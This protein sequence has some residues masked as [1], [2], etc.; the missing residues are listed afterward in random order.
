VSVA[1]RQEQRQASRKKNNPQIKEEF[2]DRKATSA[3][4]LVRARKCRRVSGVSIGLESVTTLSGALGGKQLNS[5]AKDWPRRWAA[6]NGGLLPPWALPKRSSL[7]ILPFAKKA[8][9]FVQRCYLRG[10]A[11][12]L[13]MPVGKQGMFADSSVEADESRF[14]PARIQ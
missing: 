1:D 14:A 8:W 12:H 5:F 6:R 10:H 7:G 9:I 2:L 13:P 3:H 11:Y 4:G